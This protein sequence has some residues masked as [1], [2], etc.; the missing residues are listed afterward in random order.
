MKNSYINYGGSLK[1]PI[2]REGGRGVHEKPIHTG[3]LPK[4]GDLDSCIL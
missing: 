4:K 1:Y 3:K 2:F